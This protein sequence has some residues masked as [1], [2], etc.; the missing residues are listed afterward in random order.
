MLIEK[1][2]RTISMHP[3]ALLACFVC[4][5][6]LSAS[7][8]YVIVH[9]KYQRQLD[10]KNQEVETIQKNNQDLTDQNTELSN[11]LQK[12]EDEQSR[13][14]AQLSAIE[15]QKADQQ[16]PEQKDNGFEEMPPARS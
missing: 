15:A 13:L 2:K 14:K 9:D 8:T 10:N 7:V 4:L 12:L 11:S 5:I 6:G 3:I 16:T 1:T